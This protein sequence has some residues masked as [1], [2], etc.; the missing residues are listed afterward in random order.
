MTEI[1]Q[2]LTLSR[3]IRTTAARAPNKVAIEAADRRITYKSLVANMDR[4]GNACAKVYGL[5][6]GDR[7]ALISPNCP[8]YIEIVAGLS[9]RGFVTATLNPHLTPAELTPILEDCQPRLA[10]LHPSCTGLRSSIEALGIPLLVLGKPYQ[11]LLSKASARSP[12]HLVAGTDTFA[13]S[14]TSGTTG[15]PKGVQLPHRSRA[16]MALACATEY[17]CFGFNDR[18]LSLAPLYHGAG[19]AFAVSIIS[20]GG[21][22]VLFDKNDPTLIAQ[23]LGV[24]DISGVFMVPTHFK[25]LYDIPENTFADYIR[26]HKL[27]TIISNAAA[28]A[29]SYKEETVARFGSGL[30]HETY[31]STE[32]GI[33][34]NIRPDY[35]L[36]KPGSVGTPFIHMDVEIRRED[37]SLCAPGEVGELYARGPFTFNGY[38]NRPDATAETLKDGWVTVQDLASK[39]GD[40][41]ITISG[42]MKDMV[43]S[44]GVNI[45]PSEV[46]AVL[47]KQ[48]GITEVAVVGLPDAEWGERLHAF[49]VKATPD[50]INVESLISACRSS[51]SPHKI[52][53]GIT[54]IDAL[55]RNASGK[56]L[57]RVLR[58]QGVS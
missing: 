6:A 43:V 46:E 37:G 8:E 50:P 19:F 30:L 38:L 42:R 4:V 51:L 32:A 44:G 25:R 15:L 52:P 26:G 45:Y 16:I 31:G 18:F 12:Q 54:S 7:I 22:C 33:V 9:D 47:A 10:L 56:I 24:G 49:V 23:R 35:L 14:Y 21:T 48:P 5:T 41:F 55:P 11:S 13:I 57:K 17:G 58:E 28:L 36:D 20:F 34:T 40:G 3:G 2:P 53:R 39:D 29:Q 1:A 27:K